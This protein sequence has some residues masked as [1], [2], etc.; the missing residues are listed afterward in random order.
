[1]TEFEEL[2]IS[3]YQ[4]KQIGTAKQ[5]DDSFQCEC[6]FDPG[7]CSIAYCAIVLNLVFIEQTLIDLTWRVE[8]IAI[9][10]ID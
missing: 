10:S 6:Q 1:M 8:K 5:Q 3:T 4:N 9:A 2:S 7:Q